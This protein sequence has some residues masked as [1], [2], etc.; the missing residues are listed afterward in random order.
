MVI[1]FCSTY[2]ECGHGFCIPCCL[3]QVV[4]GRTNAYNC[5]MCNVKSKTL[6]LL[7]EGPAHKKRRSDDMFQH[8]V[9]VDLAAE[10]D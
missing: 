10:Q 2:L 8:M 9:D 1:D 3:N 5:A 7:H 6:E 4:T